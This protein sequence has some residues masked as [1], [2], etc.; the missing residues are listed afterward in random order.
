[1]EDQHQ[2]RPPT[3]SHHETI[4]TVQQLSRGKA[5][6]SDSSSAGVYKHDGP[7]F[8]EHLTALF[9]AMRRQGE[10]PQDFKGA[11]IIYLYKRIGNR[12]LCDNHRGNFLLDIAGTIFVH[13]LLNGLHNYL[14]QI[15]LA[16]S[17]CGCRRYRGTMDRPLRCTLGRG[18]G[19]Y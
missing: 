6:A 14:D 16:K 17:Q 12:Q 3:L 4:R 19:A 9:Q 1:M 2:P 11:T 15:F 18:L 8:M 13:I 7:K 5:P 10:V